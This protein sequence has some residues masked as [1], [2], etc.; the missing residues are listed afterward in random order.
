MLRI[1]TGTSVAP[2]SCGTPAAF[3]SDDLVALRPRR[4]V[5]GTGEDRLHD[6]LRLDRRSEFGQ[7]ILVHSGTRLVLAGA[8]ALDRQAAL[9]ITVWLVAAGKQRV[10]AAAESFHLDHGASLSRISLAS[11]E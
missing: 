1:K 6:P 2:A 7:R 3:A 10:E 11:A 5:D 8:Q 9:F 4:V